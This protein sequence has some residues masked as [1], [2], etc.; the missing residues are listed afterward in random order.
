MKTEEN[1]S[2]MT[3][4]YHSYGLLEITINKI[5]FRIYANNCSF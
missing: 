4:I 5:T 2:M 1:N 3:N